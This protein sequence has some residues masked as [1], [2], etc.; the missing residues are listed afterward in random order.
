MTEDW[1]ASLDRR[2]AVTAVAI[3]LSKAFDSVC[4]SL[5]LAKLK[6]LGFSNTGIELMSAYLRGRRQRVKLD[7]VYSD[8]ELLSPGSLKGAFRTS[9]V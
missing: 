3:D 8:G 7:G 5:L 4:H 9:T 2:E 6:A 1:R